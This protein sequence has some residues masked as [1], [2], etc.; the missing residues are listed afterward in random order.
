M[1]KDTLKQTNKAI[2]FQSKVA[3]KSNFEQM[4]GQKPVILHISCHGIV[5]ERRTNNIGL[6]LEEAKD[7]S[8]FL[9]FETYEG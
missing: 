4:I 8:N 3:T 1:I 2:K 5:N 9:L 6:N 7:S